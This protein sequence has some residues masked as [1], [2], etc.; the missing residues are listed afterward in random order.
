VLAFA[1]CVLTPEPAV[2]AG[3]GEVMRE[4]GGWQGKQGVV[5]RWAQGDVLV[6]KLARRRGNGRAAAVTAARGLQA[7]RRRLPFKA[8]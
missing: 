1:G 5:G 7:G 8:L 3:R 2:D 4:V 6:G